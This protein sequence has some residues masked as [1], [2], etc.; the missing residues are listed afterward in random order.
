MV[1][2]TFGKEIP[3]T[4]ASDAAECN[5]YSK[6]AIDIHKQTHTHSLTHT[7]T[8]THTRALARSEQKEVPALLELY[9]HSTRDA[10][11]YYNITIKVRKRDM[12]TY[13]HDISTST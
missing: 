6:Y 11:V 4:T 8:H 1:I 12:H 5:S 13:H 7:Y 2:N 3:C 10:P 9:E